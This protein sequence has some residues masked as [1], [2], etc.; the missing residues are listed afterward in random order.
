MMR[1]FK[2]KSTTKPRI[3]YIDTLNT[4]NKSEI[5][6]FIFQLLLL[7]IGLVGFLYCVS[8][9]V[10]MHFGIFELILICVPCLVVASILTLNKKVF[11][12]FISIFVAV[13]IFIPLFFR[14]LFSYIVES[15][16][17]CYNM[18]IQIVV[19]EGYTNYASAMTEDISEKITDTT[20][21]GDYYN[22]V[23][24]VLTILFSV[25]F[26]LTLI[27]RHLVFLSALPCFA[28]LTPSLYFGAVPDS[29]AFVIFI[30]GIVGCYAQSIAY[31]LIHKNVKSKTKQKHSI[32]KAYNTAASG[33]FSAIAVLV[34]S[35]SVSSA[36]YSSEVLQIESMRE[37]IDNAAEYLLNR[38]FYK[39]YE[40]AE[41]AIG[42]LIDGEVLTLETPEFRNLPVMTVTTRTNS[43]LYLRGWIG[44]DLSD[45]GWIVV[46]ENDDI[47]YRK[48]VGSEFNQHTQF[49]NFTKIVSNSELESANNSNDTKKLGFVYDTV[50]VK[51]K[52]TKSLMLF[53]PI[54]G[55]NDDI[56]GKYRG[57]S[58][59]GDTVAFFVDKRP[60]GNTYMMD[61]A[62]QSLSDRDFYLNF[63]D[64]QKEYRLLQYQLSSKEYN[65]SEQEK[66]IKEEQAYSKYVKSNYL[67]VPGSTAFL[68]ETIDEVTS[69]YITNFDKALAIER[70]LKTNFT[71]AQHFTR[72]DGSAIDKVEYM[73][74]KSKT[75]YCTYFATAMT[76]MLRRI[77][78][79]A[80]YVVGYHAFVTDDTGES[81]YV[82]N[83]E[84]DNYH[85]WVEVYFDGIGW[86]TFD[87]TPG[88]GDNL[89]LRDYDYLD[90]PSPNA[91]ETPEDTTDTPD[92]EIAPPEANRSPLEADAEA[93]ADLPMPMLI[94]ILIISIFIIL[95]LMIILLLISLGIKQHFNNYC[96]KLFTFDPTSFTIAVYPCILRLISSL[97]YELRRG[98]SIYDFALRIDNKFKLSVSLSSIITTLEMTQFSKNTVDEKTAVEVREYFNE[99]S[100]AVFYSL[101]VFKKYYYMATIGK[102]TF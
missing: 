12:P 8:T 10:N 74:S 1:F 27:K 9:S 54:A 67:T 13:V 99:L 43:S 51:A 47:E 48:A 96:N 32:G 93:P 73:F 80:R 94:V 71:Y 66:F 79:P 45:D 6:P 64:K 17:F 68:D 89:F 39:Q 20:L 40:T 63:D 41:G 69:K 52:F 25:L 36:I 75:G 19:D 3:V 60:S 26:A 62:V 102:R 83:I 30:S 2:E 37:F 87:P 35:F 23:I 98:E 59:L 29:I 100:D 56:D 78:I 88:S 77:G 57:I 15:F 81:K 16:T 42:G 97:G 92:P 85:A 50:T 91:Q 22:C 101:N 58:M 76:V 49:Y 95:I 82:R 4:K 46:D 44:T 31:I 11:I 14:K 21:I 61:A 72:V 33:M 18:V 7:S 24:T 34:L 38:I 28:V 70:Y 90:D 86:I 5:V 53:L 84:D 55:L 65:L